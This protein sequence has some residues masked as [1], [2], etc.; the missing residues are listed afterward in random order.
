MTHYEAA[1][2]TARR[3]EM[4]EIVEQ[5]LFY[6]LDRPMVH[7][8]LSGLPFMVSVLTISGLCICCIKFHPVLKFSWSGLIWGLPGIDTVCF[9]LFYDWSSSY[10]CHLLFQYCSFI[11]VTGKL[12]RY[13]GVL[14]VFS[15]LVRVVNMFFRELFNMICLTATSSR[16]WGRA[17]R[18]FTTVLVGFIRRGLP[19]ICLTMSLLCSLIRLSDFVR[20]KRPLHW[21]RTMTLA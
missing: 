1:I 9:Y 2:Y 12:N 14:Y 7:S 5:T 16:A 20:R 3:L 21:S 17:I 19:S 6:F 10:F 4:C 8:P 11:S 13:G 18:T 15:F